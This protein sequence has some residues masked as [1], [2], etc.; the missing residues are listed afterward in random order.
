L[1]REIQTMAMPCAEDEQVVTC[2]SKEMQSAR[3]GQVMANRL[4]CV[5]RVMSTRD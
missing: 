1:V 5:A 3:G 4:R 2:E